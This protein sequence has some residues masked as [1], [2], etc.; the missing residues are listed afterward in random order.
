MTESSSADN[1]R[2][3]RIETAL[4]HVEHDVEQLHQAL[5]AQQREIESFRRILERIEAA[6]D[7]EAGLPSEVRDPL[8]EKPPHY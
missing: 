5:V 8:A 4:M 1:D 7:R 3:V 6:L 2:I